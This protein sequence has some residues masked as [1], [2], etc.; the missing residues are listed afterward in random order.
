MAANL[1][2]RDEARRIA[3]NVAK[4]SRLKPSRD[5]DAELVSSMPARN[6]PDH[7]R[8]KTRQLKLKTNLTD[9]LAS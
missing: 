4:P 1:L 6:A 7:N 9:P 3:A 5:H 2:T 8:H